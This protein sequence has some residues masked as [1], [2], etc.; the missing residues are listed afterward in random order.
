MNLQRFALVF[1]IVFLVIGIAGFVP[2]LTQSHTHP[3]VNVQAGMGLL[4]G[5]FPVNILH[6][7]VH[8]LFG[9]WGL[10]AARSL[11]GSLAYA[12]GTAVIYAVLTILGL[13]PA[14]KLHSTFGLIPLYGHDIWLHAVLALVAGYF[15]FVHRETQGN[16]QRTAATN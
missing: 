11:G 13:I 15:G 16:T 14:M 12:R 9:A 6:N 10:A 3:D 7:V 5:L 4:F 2:G 1:G 8:L